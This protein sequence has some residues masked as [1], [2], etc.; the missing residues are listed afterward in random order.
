MSTDVFGHYDKHPFFGLKHALLAVVARILPS[1]I[2]RARSERPVEISLRRKGESSL[3]CHA[4]N[5]NT[6]AMHPSTETQ[7]EHHISTGRVAISIRSKERPESVQLLPDGTAL[8]WTHDRGII[9]FELPDVDILETV[10]V[11]YE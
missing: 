8:P 10:H 6:V 3:V 5:I 1:P 4:V 2:I 9:R 11:E 7:Y